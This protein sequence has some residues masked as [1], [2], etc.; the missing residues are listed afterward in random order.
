MREGTRTR[1]TGYGTLLSDR[2]A[3]RSVGIRC[4]G[5]GGGIRW[6]ESR[7]TGRGLAFPSV[8]AIFWDVI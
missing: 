1:L 2:L 5:D 6:W 4:V 3:G 7:S 8:R